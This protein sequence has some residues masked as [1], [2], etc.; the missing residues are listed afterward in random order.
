MRDLYARVIFPRLLELSVGGKVFAKERTKALKSVHGEV[1]E[2]GFG[3]GLN[4]PYY[5]SSV[6]RLVALDPELMLPAKVSE[7]IATASFPVE[8]VQQVGEH[9]PFATG[10]FDCVVTTLALCTIADPICALSEIW[11]VLRTGGT[12]AFL[13]HGRSADPRMARFQDRLN[14]LWVRS[15][16]ARGCNINRPIDSLLAQ[17]GLRIATA[18][19]LRPW[20]AAY[21]HGDVPRDRN[22]RAAP[23]NTSPKVSASEAIGLTSSTP[24]AASA[25]LSKSRPHQ[26]SCAQ[27]APLPGG[28]FRET[29]C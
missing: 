10:Q 11:R 16:I 7:R 5:P 21:S 15:G 9:L 25:P 20:Q 19:A 17:S 24:T 12:S 6:T 23:P 13:E 22:P 14:P 3:T 1:L 26:A 4:L 28:R 29:S 18:R 2:V 27:A 8:R